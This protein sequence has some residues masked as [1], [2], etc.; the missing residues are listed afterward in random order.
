MIAMEMID[1]FDVNFYYFG[2]CEN[3]GVNVKIVP[4]TA[5][6]KN[7]K[8]DPKTTKKAASENVNFKN[9]H[10]E[11]SEDVD[12]RNNEKIYCVKISEKIDPRKIQT[13]QRRNEDSRRVLLQIQTRI[14]F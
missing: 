5:H 1:Y 6:I 2:C 10:F 9:L 14:Y 11:I 13:G 3:N 8:S 4:K 7:K 12:T